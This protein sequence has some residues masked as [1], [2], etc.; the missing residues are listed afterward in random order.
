MGEFK[1]HHY[2]DCESA[3]ND[4]LTIKPKAIFLDHFLKG[5]NGVDALPL[6][7]ENLPQVKIA[8]I[9]CQNDK[10]VLADAFDKGATNYFR[11][12]VLIMQIITFFELIKINQTETT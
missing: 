10:K 7:K 8:I 3:L 5:L 6:F 12:D 9:S 11:K 1:T 4:L 2:T